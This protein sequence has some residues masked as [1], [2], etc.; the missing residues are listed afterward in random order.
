[1]PKKSQPNTTALN[2]LPE[3]IAQPV[4][5]SACAYHRAQTEYDRLTRELDR[6][7]VV[8]NA[9]DENL[10]STLKNHG[11]GSVVIEMNV[12]D[13]LVAVFDESRGQHSFLLLKHLPEAKSND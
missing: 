7:A 8:L 3:P 6:A 4:W 2:S 1:M 13:R 11:I 12:T 10:S 9:A 5:N